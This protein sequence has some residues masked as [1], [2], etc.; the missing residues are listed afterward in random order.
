MKLTDTN[1]WGLTALQKRQTTK[2]MLQSHPSIIDPYTFIL[3]LFNVIIIII[4]IVIIIII[5]IIINIIIIIII[6]IIIKTI[7]KGTS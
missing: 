3:L 2:Q 6:I 5:I 7:T 4:I 1:E